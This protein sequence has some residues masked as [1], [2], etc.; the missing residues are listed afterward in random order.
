MGIIS[1]GI[2]INENGS[3]S[4]GDYLVA[5][6]LKINDF[7]HGGANYSLRTHKD[8]TRLERNGELLFE[9]VPGAA[10]HDF[11]IAED[12]CQFGIS[13]SGGCMVTICLE[14]QTEYS[15]TT[16]A[17]DG[18]PV[19]I[20]ANRQSGKATIALTLAEEAQNI[21]IKKI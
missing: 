6:K 8:V 17:T 16:C 13:G 3:I 9:A 11:V 7:S 12:A 1:E 18:H 14:P 2:R 20:T 21:V 4:F 10:V 15:Y 19:S 5:E